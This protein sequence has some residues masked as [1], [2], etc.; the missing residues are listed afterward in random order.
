MVQGS[1]DSGAVSASPAA[2]TAAAGAYQRHRPEATALY[3]IVRDNLRAQPVARPDEE[4][5]AAPEATAARS[6][7]RRSTARSTMA[8]WRFRIPKYARKELEAYLGCGFL[9]CGCENRVV[10]FQL[11]GRGFCPSCG[12]RRMCA[13]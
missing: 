12:G 10:A 11:Q 3:Q 4:R 8:R 1:R 9:G 6:T 5:A 2:A 7:S 13:T